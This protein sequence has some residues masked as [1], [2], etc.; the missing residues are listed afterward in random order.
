M[1]D[2]CTR[3]I[4]S[5]TLILSAWIYSGLV[6]PSVLSWDLAPV[7]FDCGWGVNCVGEAG[8]IQ[9]REIIA[10]HIS[11]PSHV[12]AERRKGTPEM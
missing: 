4:L 5:D 12:S 6:E 7:Q 11:S 9:A 2:W 10:A 1:A 3:L 8:I